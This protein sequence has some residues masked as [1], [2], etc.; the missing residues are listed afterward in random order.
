[1]IEAFGGRGERTR[2]SEATSCRDS[3][4]K[5]SQ[6][7]GNTKGSKHA[8]SH[9][10]S[11]SPKSERETCKDE[12]ENIHQFTQGK[13]TESKGKKG[14]ETPTQT[15]GSTDPH[16]G[17]AHDTAGSSTGKTKGSTDLEQQTTGKRI[18]NASIRI[19]EPDPT[20]SQDTESKKKADIDASGDF[21]SDPSSPPKEGELDPGYEGDAPDTKDADPLIEI[22]ATPVK[23][24]TI[25]SPRT[26]GV[27]DYTPPDESVLSKDSPLEAGQASIDKGEAVDFVQDED[28]DF[29]EDP[30]P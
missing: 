18:A 23:T 6:Y 15:K 7:E 11:S 4:S 22:S 13:T 8:G 25:F 10:E 2:E 1:M 30:I 20:S 3:T 5:E 21:P 29:E 16:T 28:E 12:G 17:K 24:T 19:G 14:A 9:T 26:R 27:P